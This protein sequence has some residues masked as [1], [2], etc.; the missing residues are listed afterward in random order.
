MY[1]AI[2][3]IA[4]QGSARADTLEGLLLLEN[5]GH[6]EV[7]LPSIVAHQPQQTVGRSA[8]GAQRSDKH[9]GIDHYLVHGPLPAYRRAV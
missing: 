4:A 2:D 1:Y 8:I 9:I 3:V 5:Q 7:D 6:R